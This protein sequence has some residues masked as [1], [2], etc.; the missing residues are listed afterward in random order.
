MREIDPLLLE[1]VMMRRNIE[2][3]RTA[4]TSQTACMTV[5]ALFLFGLFLYSLTHRQSVV[6]AAST[7]ELSHASVG[8]LPGYPGLPQP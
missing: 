5:V 7:L 3:S 8:S 4:V 6:A 1:D 2:T